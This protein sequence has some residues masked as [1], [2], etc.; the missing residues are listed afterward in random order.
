VNNNICMHA[1]TFVCYVMVFM[2]L[3]TCVCVLCVCVMFG[4][5]VC[6]HI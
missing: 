3:R 1:C 5:S 4:V 2:Y 6:D